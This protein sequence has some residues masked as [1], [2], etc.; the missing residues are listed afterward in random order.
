MCHREKTSL[1]YDFPVINRFKR[2]FIVHRE[3]GLREDHL[4]RTECMGFREAV[5]GKKSAEGEVCGV[6]TPSVL[7][8][9]FRIVFLCV[10]GVDYHAICAGWFCFRLKQ[11]CRHPARI[12]DRSVG[13]AP[14][15]VEGNDFNVVV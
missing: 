6:V 12:L 2:V 8:S 1:K 11:I 14:Y 3:D 10:A 7:N 5:G 13:I 15:F 4:S 9:M